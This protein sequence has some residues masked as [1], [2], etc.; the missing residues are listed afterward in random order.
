MFGDHPG[1][2]NVTSHDVNLL[3]QTSPIRQN[4]YRLHPQK[5]DQMKKEQHLEQLAAVFSRLSDANLTVK[6]AK[7]TCCQASVTYLGHEVGKG[8]LTSGTAPIWTDDCQAAFFQFKTFLTQDPVLLTL[9]F[10]E[11][12][13]LHHR[14][15]KQK[16]N[17]EDKTSKGYVITFL[18]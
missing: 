13:I 17:P 7:T 2:C 6:L 15:T 10:N 9:D 5:S 3:P 16:S 14:H 1:C 8:R 4:P 11:P 18:K 12:F